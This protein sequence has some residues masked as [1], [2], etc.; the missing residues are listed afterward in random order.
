V[1]EAFGLKFFQIAEITELKKMDTLA[2][3]S[4]KIIAT[5]YFICLF[6]YNLFFDIANGTDYIA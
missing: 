5:A 3:S 1:D 6:I 4:M 2:N